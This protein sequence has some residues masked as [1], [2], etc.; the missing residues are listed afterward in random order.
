MQDPV[1]EIFPYPASVNY[2]VSLKYRDKYTINNT[3]YFQTTKHVQIFYRAL[4]LGCSVPSGAHSLWNL[5]AI[6]FSSKRKHIQASKLNVPDFITS[7]FA[8]FQEL[9]AGK[10]AQHTYL[11]SNDAHFRKMGW[12]KQ[13]A[14]VA[15]TFLIHLLI[16]DY[17]DRKF[18]GAICTLWSG[19]LISSLTQFSSGQGSWAIILEAFRQ[20]ALT[21][22]LVGRR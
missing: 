21:P 8:Q 1:T 12:R 6:I 5:Y 10:V 3:C 9:H 13:E 14:D 11:A 4:K 18:A 2:A 20:E 7:L 22:E 19:M 16:C 17:P 15:G